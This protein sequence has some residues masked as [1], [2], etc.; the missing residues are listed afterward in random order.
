VIFAERFLLRSR[1]FAKPENVQADKV[2]RVSGLV[3]P[4]AYP[5]LGPEALRWHRLRARLD[6]P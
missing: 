6:R 2:V 1:G 4:R 5:F 3:S